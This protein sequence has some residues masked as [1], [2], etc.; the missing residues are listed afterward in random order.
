MRPNRSHA[1]AAAVCVLFALVRTASAQ[2]EPKSLEPSTS[3]PAGECLQWKSPQ[4]KPYWYRLPKKLSAAKPA[5][6]IFMLHGTGMNQGWPFYNYPI[7]G[8]NWRNDDVIVAPEG[9]TPGNG[10]TFNF[11]QGPADGEQIAGLIAFFKKKLPIG[12]VYLYGHSQGAFFCYW[13]AGAYPELTDGIVAHAGNVLDVKHPK[14]A[15]DKIGIGILHGRAD[16]VVP[17]ECAT[18]TEK[19]YRDEGYKKLKLYIVEGLNDQTGHWPLPQQV[20][21][22]FDWLDQ[23]TT[24]SAAQS[25]GVAIDQLG[26]EAPDLLVVRNAIADAEKLLPKAKGDEKV[27]LDAQLAALRDVLEQSAVA[28]AAALT[29][30]SAL[31]DPKLP[32]GAWAAH[33]RAV[34]SAFSGLASWQKALKPARAAAD[35]H[36]K[37]VDAVLAKFDSTKA[38]S[39][40]SA[41]K[42]LESSFLAPRYGD[43]RATVEPVLATP[44]KGVPQKEVDATRALIKTREADES[45]GAAA[46]AAKTKEILESLKS[47]HPALFETRPAGE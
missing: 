20:A 16:A 37:A 13:F 11:L 18:R 32:Y 25:V 3:A 38:A 19:I 5:T 14:L 10:D 35:K 41:A 36:G 17:V 21:E 2:D 42:E 1:L 39:V 27:A 15:K 47:K 31:A 26:R 45:A 28:H 29:T 46:A 34:D 8:S 30:D 43:L 9:M 4:G 22:M 23:V 40:K 24:Q 44:P 6:L 12:R 33:F 7:V